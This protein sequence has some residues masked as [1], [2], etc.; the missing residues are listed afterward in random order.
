MCVLR[1]VE[2]KEYSFRGLY[3]C[4]DALHPVRYIGG[5]KNS[6]VFTHERAYRIGGGV[7]SCCEVEIQTYPEEI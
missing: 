5:H 3:R 2:I 4:I 6:M 7:T 1:R